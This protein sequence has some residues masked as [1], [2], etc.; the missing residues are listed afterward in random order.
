MRWAWAQ[1]L[2]CGYMTQTNS[3]PFLPL[4]NSGAMLEV[5]PERNQTGH[6]HLKIG[7]EQTLKIE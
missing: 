2:C 6:Q 5:N 4:A 7:Y 1:D 3:G